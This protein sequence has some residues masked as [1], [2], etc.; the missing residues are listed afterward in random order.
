[1]D[2]TRT[3]P[4]VFPIAF[5]RTRHGLCFVFLF[6]VVRALLASVLVLVFLPLHL[7]LALFLL[8]LLLQH[9]LVL[10]H[11]LPA[12]HVLF[13]LV[14]AL[15]ALVLVLVLLLLLL[16]L[17]LLLLRL[18]PLLLVLPVLS[19]LVLFVLVRV[20]FFTWSPLTFPEQ[21]AM[22]IGQRITGHVSNESPYPMS[23]MGHGS[24]PHDI[25]SD[26]YSISSADVS[27]SLRTFIMNGQLL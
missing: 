27:C 26:S 25:A 18:Q 19:V 16:I 24:R 12:P 11:V 10:H 2:G 22:V 7:L 20:C 1:M 15:Y 13:L 21:S 6:F 4:I 23:H 5:V 8:R 9:L 17:V 14:L 3:G